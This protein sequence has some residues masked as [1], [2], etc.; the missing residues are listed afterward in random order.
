[1]CIIVNMLDIKDIKGLD[2]EDMLKSYNGKNPYINYMKKK[3]LT[4]KKYFLTTNQSKY[5]KLYYNFIPKKINKI[6]EITNYYSEQL[7]EE[8]KLSTPINKI[9]IETLLAE[10]DKAIHVICKFYK[11]QKDVKLIWIPKTQLIDDI[12]F[13]EI[14]IS[15]DYNKIPRIR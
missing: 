1:M 5:V 12:H 2:S 14:E 3:S 15:I 10:S 8:Y 9:F 4:E 13:E 7:K 6:I 11:N